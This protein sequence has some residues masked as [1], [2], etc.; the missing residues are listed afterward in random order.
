MTRKP[1][2]FRIQVPEADSRFRNPPARFDRAALKRSYVMFKTPKASVFALVL[3]S[4]L[5]VLCVGV[6]TA[7]EHPVDPTQIAVAAPAPSVDAEPTQQIE[8]LEATPQEPEVTSMSEI[9]DCQLQCFQEFTACR[10][11]AGNSGGPGFPAAAYEECVNEYERC[12]AVECGIG[13]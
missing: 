11:G 12:L 5:S 6:L 7:A 2:D 8:G 9:E 1:A 3:L 13:C 10:Q 4:V